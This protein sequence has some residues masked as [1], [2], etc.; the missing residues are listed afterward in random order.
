MP[1]KTSFK[2]LGE[3]EIILR[4]EKKK[5][6]YFEEKSLKNL[7]SWD[8]TNK[9]WVDEKGYIVKSEQMFTP[10]NPEIYIKLNKK[11]KKPE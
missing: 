1:V 6:R 4:E 8:F 11:Y 9:F 10:K 5:V 2:Y 7:I 3:V